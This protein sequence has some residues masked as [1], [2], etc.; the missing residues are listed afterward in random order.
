MSNVSHRSVF[1]R[2]VKAKA[3]WGEAASAFP[4]K[5]DEDAYNE[6]VDDILASSEPTA[7]LSR[8][9]V[10]AGYT[11]YRV[12]AT[13]M[14]WRL[15]PKA[16]GAANPFFLDLYHNVAEMLSGGDCFLHTLA[17][18]GAHGTGGCRGTGAER[19]AVSRRDPAVLFCSPTM[20][21]GVDIATLN[22]VYMRNVPPTPANYA[23]R[24]GRARTQ[25]TAC[26]GADLL[27][28][29]FAA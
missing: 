7:W 13:V 25:R 29:P 19:G 16:P 17:G 1:G 15:G 9:D 2:R 27:R 5:I 28:G 26:A 12:P 8:L 10:E 6:I 4:G 20:E 23:Q 3:T 14:E 18:P 22:T 11:G 24:S 21:L